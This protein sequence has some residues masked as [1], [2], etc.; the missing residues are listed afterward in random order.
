MLLMNSQYDTWSHKVKVFPFAFN[1]PVRTK[2][3]L[4]P[5]EL[6]CGQKPKKP[7]MFN[8]YSTTDSFGNCK[9]TESSA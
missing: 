8:L 4:S 2:T 7:I 5:Y 1:S 6:L 9:P 3:N